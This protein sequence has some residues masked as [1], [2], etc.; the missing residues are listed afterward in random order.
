MEQLRLELNGVPFTPDPSIDYGF[1]F[2][3]WD[4][5][6]Q[7]E[8]PPGVSEQAY[9]RGLFRDML[10]NSLFAITAF[11]M[12]VPC[13]FHPFW[14]EV[15]KEVQA[16]PLDK[17]LDIWARGH[18]KSTVITGARVIQQI[19]KNPEITCCIF[20]YSKAAAYK[21]FHQIKG[22]LEGSDFLKW[23]YPDVLYQDP[24]VEA[25]K[26]SEDGGLIVRRRG[27]QKEPTLA[28]SGLIEGMP[29][30]FHFSLRVYDDIMVE[31]I[32]D[33][34]D[35][36]EKLKE[37]FDLSKNLGLDGGWEWVVGTPYHHDDIIQTLRSRT[38]IDG[39][40]SYNVRLKP[41][42][43]NGEWNGRPVFHSEGYIN[44]LKVNKNKFS[45]Q[46]L[47]NPTPVEI[48]KL[49]WENVKELTQ[50]EIPSNIYKFMLVDPAGER[51]DRTGDSWAIIVVG[52]EPFRDQDLGASNIYILDGVIAEMTHEDAISQVV[53]IYC[54]NGRITQLG[55]EKVGQSTFE[56][57]VANALRAKNIILSSDVGNLA[58]LRPSG[59][60]KA[61][62]IEAALAWPL[63][64]HKLHVNQNLP[65]AFKERLRTEAERFPRWRD[66]GLDALS[67]AY[68]L[69]KDYRFGLKPLARQDNRPKF[70]ANRWKTRRHRASW[71]N[72]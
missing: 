37:R 44:D 4:A 49:Q 14:I 57:H 53:D 27:F 48:R 22:I 43:E 31:D 68:D 18:G 11:V 9:H 42:T 40:P 8:P 59:R 69:I 70:L 61:E 2:F 30:G 15:C 52:V 64:N 62:R 23:C 58:I 10:E 41:A 50:A 16:G 56:I 39:R 32:A 47:L 19:L 63:T 26:W 34:A 65:V 54:R 51:R 60:T 36:M 20:S 1:D 5:E 45:S 71:L 67:Y 13:A 33:S 6:M 66:D 28:A 24:Q 72:V 46:Q 38:T 17:T 29:T 25:P 12:R 21:F 35:M 7:K 3:A 55:V